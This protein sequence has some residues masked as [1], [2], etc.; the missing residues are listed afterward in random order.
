MAR[1]DEARE[2]VERACV[3][4]ASDLKTLLAGI[5]RDQTLA[6]DAFQRTVLKAIQAAD[7]VDL[8]TLRGWLFRIAVNEARQLRRESRRETEKL[9]S[10]AVVAGRQTGSAF[11]SLISESQILKEEFV[12]A[13]RCSLERLPSNHKEVVQRRIYE[14]QQ[15]SDIANAMGVPLGTVLTWMRRALEQ[16]RNDSQLKNAVKPD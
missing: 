12:Q 16:L 13:V 15:F 14:G 10:A 3:E 5:L 11:E 8:R 9:Q 2:T 7:T 6:E 4:L 1:S